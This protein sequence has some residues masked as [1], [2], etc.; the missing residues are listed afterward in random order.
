MSFSRVQPSGTSATI[1]SNAP[2]TGTSAQKRTREESGMGEVEPEATTRVGQAVIDEN[3]RIVKTETLSQI[4][5][6]QGQV[7]R[8][9]SHV[10]SI[11]VENVTEETPS[12]PRRVVHVRI[13]NASERALSL[14]SREHHVAK[15]K[16][17]LSSL[18]EEIKILSLKCRDHKQPSER[19]VNHVWRRFVAIM[20]NNNE[21]RKFVAQLKDNCAQE[22]A[23]LIYDCGQIANLTVLPIN[24]KSMQSLVACLKTQSNLTARQICMAICGLGRLAETQRMNGALDASTINLLL[25]KLTR[26]PNVD[27][28]VIRGVFEGLGF[29][30]YARCIDDVIDATNIN[31]LFIQLTNGRDLNSQT[32]GNVLYGLSLMCKGKGLNDALDTAPINV[33]LAQLTSIRDC[34]PRDIFTIFYS[35]GC[36]AQANGFN[37]MVDVKAV[38]I[39]FDRLPREG[40]LPATGIC[41]LIY[42]LGLLAEAKAL[43]GAVNVRLMDFLLNAILHSPTLRSEKFCDL[44]Y[45]LGSLAQTTSLN[46]AACLSGLV[47]GE[48]INTMLYSIVDLSKLKFDNLFHGLKLLAEVKGII[49]E[50][51]SSLLNMLL[52]QLTHIDNTNAI[53]QSL[54]GIGLLAQA[55]NI[56]GKIAVSTTNQLLRLLVKSPQFKSEQIDSVLE[57]LKLLNQSDRIDGNE[58]DKTLLKLLFSKSSRFKVCLMM[59]FPNPASDFSQ[60]PRELIDLII[61][62]MMTEMLN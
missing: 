39:L 37:E 26:L 35:L 40:D 57:G 61:E 34:P 16:S 62:M 50:I 46:G 7:N 31:R 1:G 4:N 12:T 49:G 59:H 44:I 18:V 53:S 41:N 60:L 43:S 33:L 32:I 13:E 23:N 36:L 3:G 15:A 20:N 5:S 21:F 54:F 8:Q 52:D 19:H 45:G 58:I 24:V 29:L 2:L 9:I 56:K 51:D 28:Y 55:G 47:K 11:S 6:L 14:Q 25:L 42:G 48:Y 17:K 22:I 10:E 30:V 27:E 38:N